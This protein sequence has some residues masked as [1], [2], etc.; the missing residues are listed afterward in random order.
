MGV[1]GS[2]ISLGVLLGPLMQALASYWITPQATF[3]IAVAL[4]MMIILLI[5]VGYKQR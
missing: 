1:R 5:I 2:A 4:T 3:A